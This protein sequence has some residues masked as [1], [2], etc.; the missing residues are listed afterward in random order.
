M[1]ENF[2]D[3]AKLKGP[4]AS[5][6]MGERSSSPISPRTT[7]TSSSCTREWAFDLL[8]NDAAFFAAYPVTRKL[9]VPGYAIDPAPTPR[10]S[11]PGRHLRSSDSPRHVTCSTA[12]N[13]RIVGRWVERTQSKAKP[14][15]DD[16]R[17]RRSRRTPGSTFQL[18]WDTATRMFQTG[19]PSMD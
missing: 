16:L 4:S 10:P 1:A 9:G 3:I 15:P 19:L 7:P 13:T 14:I 8:V 5:P 18:P 11:R 2:P 6:S 17:R 12:S